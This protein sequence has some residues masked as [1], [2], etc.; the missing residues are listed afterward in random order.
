MDAAGCCPI[1][2]ILEEALG[3]K[4]DTKLERILRYYK[5]VIS[6]SVTHLYA[7]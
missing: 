6:A 2:I 7:D 3:G 5:R 4:E 1:K